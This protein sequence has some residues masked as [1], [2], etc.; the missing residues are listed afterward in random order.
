M[1][2]APNLSPFNK[3][4]NLKFLIINL[5]WVFIVPLFIFIS[6]NML[7]ELLIDFKRKLYDENINNKLS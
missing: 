2:S 6:I 3:K 7:K 1:L 4:Y 5:S